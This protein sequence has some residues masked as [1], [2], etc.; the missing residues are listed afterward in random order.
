VTFFPRSLLWRTLV[1]LVAALVL[2]QAAAVWLFDEY[3]TRPRAMAGMRQ[4]TSHL[5]TL[6]AALETLAPQQ[7]EAFINRVAEMEG[8]RITPVRGE[9]PV[10]PAPDVAYMRM[11]RERL[12][13]T[14]GP[15]AEVYVRV[16]RAEPESFERRPPRLFYIKLTAANRQY[17]VAIPRGRIDRDPGTAAIAWGL[18]GLAIAV[19]A[20]FLIVWRLNR[21]LSEL[22]RAA[23]RLG[24]GGDPPP[25]HETGPSEIRAVARAFNQMKDDLRKAERDRATFLAGVSHDLRTPLSR[26]RLGVEMLEDKVDDATRHGMVA[27]LEDMNKI[28][29]QFIDFTRGEAG[30][31][32]LGVNLS[33]LARACCERAARAGVA[34]RCELAETPLV[35]ARP[36]ALQRAID[37]LI[38]NA[39][40]HAGGEVLVRTTVD[41][42]RTVVAV[43]DRGPGIPADMVEH[44]KQPFA[45]LDASRTGQSGAGLGLAIAERIAQLHGGGLE[46]VARDGG[47]LEARLVLEASQHGSVENA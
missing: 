19:M 30:E 11:F 36:L 3:V 47:G 40:R 34:I 6:S 7:H 25:I 14:F 24:R 44:V 17:W 45:R 18:A 1:V 33:E 29:D 27:D 21:P 32:L 38:T 37:N 10:A 35:M 5:K 13:D 26:L 43:L 46:L 20:T 42:T 4:F 16:N 39:A 12:R 23:G 22:A 31:A 28:V 8:L 15:D 9:M 2:S 41:G